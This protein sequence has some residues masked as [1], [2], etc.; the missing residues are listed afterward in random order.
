MLSIGSL[1]VVKSFFYSHMD[2]ILAIY[3][4]IHGARC[5]RRWKARVIRLEEMNSFILGVANGHEDQ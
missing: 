1:V 4:L 3:V 2:M 5:E